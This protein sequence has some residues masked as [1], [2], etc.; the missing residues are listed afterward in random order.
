MTPHG[1]ASRQRGFL[2]GL[3]WLLP[4]AAFH[5]GALSGESRSNDADD[6][7]F[8]ADHG[9]AAIRLQIDIEGLSPRQWS[10]E[11]L[12]SICTE[13]DRDGDGL[14]TAE[15]YDAGV[16][17]H[18]FLQERQTQLMQPNSPPARPDFGSRGTLST[19]AAASF[20]LRNV[21]RPLRLEFAASQLRRISG[22]GEL[23][24]RP[25]A[26]TQLFER[27]DADGNRKLT[28]RELERASTV[29]A[30]LD[31]DEDE[32]ISLDELRM[33]PSANPSLPAA[34][35]P[36]RRGDGHLVLLTP[37]RI[38]APF[39]RR[40][41]SL[42]DGEA[43]GSARD[44]RLD[45]REVALPDDLF[46]QADAD[47]D[48]YW[49]FDELWRFLERPAPLV[50]IAVRITV[51][52]P[53]VVAECSSRDER[54]ARL[55]EQSDAAVTMQVHQTRLQFLLPSGTP[56]GDADFDGGFPAQFAVLDRDRNEYLEWKE[57]Q[58]AADDDS[59]PN[60][61]FQA[62]DADRDGKVV[63]DE[64][65]AYQRRAQEMRVRSLVLVV[66]N[67]ERT[68]F[69]SLD[70]NGDG[71]LSQRELARLGDRLAEW[72][73]DGDG[74]L[75]ETEIP[76][77]YRLTLIR[78]SDRLGDF[79][80]AGMI[81]PLAAGRSAA[82]TAGPLWFQKMDRNRDGEVSPREFL[83]TIEQFQKIDLN[84]DGAIDANEAQA[85]K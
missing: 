24:D 32:T 34:N 4:L 25:L 36:A 81:R 37:D 3:V 55:L 18:P 27:L 77:Q 21:A 79:L 28:P 72:D 57:F 70:V 17:G 69:G 56:A 63:L 20:L 75:V 45:R 41:L 71:R 47:E 40:V 1:D 15:E 80:G 9:L 43:K 74:K 8:L 83:G 64:F 33:Q 62:I 30:K 35:R 12:K 6:L 10:R 85:V 26:D 67:L 61:I 39:V 42:Y 73:A 48:G 38:D 54:A 84:G 5:H 59:P 50:Q 78:E 22:T 44:L 13:A 14:L 29:L 82:P 7:L 66:E 31:F 46:A 68:L 65:L 11:L 2:R 16:A 52:S 49:D 76:Q 58:P 53:F 23:L 60:A 51:N 19:D